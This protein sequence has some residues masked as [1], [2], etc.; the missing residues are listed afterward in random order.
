MII[1]D[2][3]L[4]KKIIFLPLRK[5]PTRHEMKEFWEKMWSNEISQKEAKWLKEV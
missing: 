1:R 4:M 5:T 2:L 3:K